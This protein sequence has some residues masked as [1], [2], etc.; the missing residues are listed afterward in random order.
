MRKLIKILY[1]TAHQSERHDE[2][3]RTRVRPSFAKHC[4]KGYQHFLSFLLTYRISR[5]VLFSLYFS[6]LLS[7]SAVVPGASFGLVII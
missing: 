4:S 7:Q 1:E 2:E 6:L 5:H 3:D